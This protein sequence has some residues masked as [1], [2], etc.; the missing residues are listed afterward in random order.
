MHR[1]LTGEAQKLFFFIVSNKIYI[2]H[3][4]FYFFNIN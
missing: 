3:L 1:L 2:K 4:E